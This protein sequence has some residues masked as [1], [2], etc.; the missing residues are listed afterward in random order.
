MSFNMVS[1]KIYSETW[2]NLNIAVDYR[3][4]DI[5]LVFIHIIV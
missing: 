2:T 5:V 3:D 1:G 4:F